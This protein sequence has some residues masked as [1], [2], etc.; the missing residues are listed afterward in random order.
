MYICVCVYD[1]SGVKG[2]GGIRAS[3]AS[4][5]APSQATPP[6]STSCGTLTLDTWGVGFERHTRWLPRC[7]LEPSPLNPGPCGVKG[8]RGT[9]LIRSHLPVG[10]TVG[11]YLG[12]YGGPGWG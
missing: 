4:P 12:P 6:A 1:P 10:P 3:E 7:G 9:S 5:A 11:L 8:Y 2:W